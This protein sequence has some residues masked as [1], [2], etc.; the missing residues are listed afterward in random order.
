MQVR[1]IV[2]FGASM[3]LALAL[4]WMTARLA[5]AANPITAEIAQQA[6]RP[7]SLVK[8]G[9]EEGRAQSPIMV[10]VK[11]VNEWHTQRLSEVICW[12]DRAFVPSS[13]SMP[14]AGMPGPSG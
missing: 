3:A 13:G 12:F 2:N 10:H 9:A 4:P 6:E 7:V 14:S 1:R 5:M 8:E 11:C